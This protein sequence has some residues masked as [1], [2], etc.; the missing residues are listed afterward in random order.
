MTFYWLVLRK[1]GQS[2]FLEN[3]NAIWFEVLLPKET[4]NCEF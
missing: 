3:S 4:S 2:N 1:M